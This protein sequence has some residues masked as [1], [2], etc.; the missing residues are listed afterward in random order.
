[1]KSYEGEN[2]KNMNAKHNIT[3]DILNN[4][5]KN[6]QIL[7]TQENTIKDKNKLENIN[8]HNYENMFNRIEKNENNNIFIINKNDEIEN[9]YNS[10]NLSCISLI[11]I[12][13]GRKN[14]NKKKSNF[15]SSSFDHKNMKIKLEEIKIPSKLSKSMCMRNNK[16]NIQNI[17]SNNVLPYEET[18]NTRIIT[19]AKVRRCSFSSNKSLKDD[20]NK[21]KLE[22]KISPKTRI[23]LVSN[24]SINNNISNVVNEI[25]TLSQK[26]I[27]K[28]GEKKKEIKDYLNTNNNKAKENNNKYHHQNIYNRVCLDSIEELYEEE[29]DSKTKSKINKSNSELNSLLSNEKNNNANSYQ[30]MNKYKINISYNNSNIKNNIINNTPC[31]SSKYNLGKKNNNIFD[32]SSDEE[33]EKDKIVSKDINNNCNNN[34]ANLNNNNNKINNFEEE[35][36]EFDSNIFIK[37]LD[38]LINFNEYENSMSFMNESDINKLF[39]S[40]NKKGMNL[41]DHNSSNL[42]NNNYAF[43]N[44][45]LNNS[46]LNNRINNRYFMNDENDSNYFNIFN[47]DKKDI[48]SKK[49]FDKT[50]IKKIIGKELFIKPKIN[51]LKNLISPENLNRHYSSFCHSNNYIL[52]SNSIEIKKKS[53]KIFKNDNNSKSKLLF[54]DLKLKESIT[55]IDLIKNKKYTKIFKNQNSCINKINIDIDLNLISINQIENKRR[56]LYINSSLKTPNDKILNYNK[57][58]FAYN[59]NKKDE[60]N[61]M[62]LFTNDERKN[63]FSNNLIYNSFKNQSE[64]YISKI[65]M[66]NDFSNSKISNNKY[67]NDSLKKKREEGINTTPFI[68][69]E[70]DI[71]INDNKNSSHKKAINLKRKHKR[72]RSRNLINRNNILFFSSVK[73]YNNNCSYDNDN[74]ENTCKM[75]NNISLNSYKGDNDNSYSDKNIKKINEVDNYLYKY[76]RNDKVN[77]QNNMK[78]NE[79]EIIYIDKNDDN[80]LLENKKLFISINSYEE[81]IQKCISKA[82]EIKVK[83]INII[84]KDNNFMNKDNIFVDKAKNDID[85][86]ISLF[87][88]ELKLLKNYYLCLLVKKHYL[89]KKSEKIKLIK[90]MNIKEKR[91]MF[92]I[93]YLN[94]INFIQEKFKFDD[95]KFEIYI[96]KIIYIIE[97]YKNI[98]KYDIKYTKKIYKEENELSPY[99]LDIKKFTNIKGS[100]FLQK[101]LNDD[102]NTK[103]IIISTSIIL[104]ILYGINYFMSFYVNK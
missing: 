65:F 52:E 17:S 12:M 23:D 62:T 53:I 80:I 68:L 61:D 45:N 99:T 85:Y 88:N 70:N 91:D 75:N 7:E 14:N 64:D 103:K 6:D 28:F 89:K 44:K 100:N 63:N 84:K 47:K 40:P 58:E 42:I 78:E 82:K 9:N 15:H 90:Y 27:Y 31:I 101:L 56:A 55:H 49:N 3:F 48:Y 30:N 46:A 33:D 11:R 20:T 79:N 34:I 59:E 73:I 77:S 76:N 81:F 5:E 21:E 95:C 41:L 32:I 51:N 54:K 39:S 36:N 72:N 29:N 69:D 87:E 1:M 2:I 93:S 94:L 97:K 104:P 13:E 57:N 60:T 50:Y 37:P 96:N 66:T 67:T 74:N 8:M 19:T 83:L 98:S 18:E 86:K 43:Y 16:E 24:L 4:S 35:Q 22:N 71:I 10:D 38:N 26:Y 92:K 102:L 25:I